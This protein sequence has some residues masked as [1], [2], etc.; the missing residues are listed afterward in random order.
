MSCKKR[1]RLHLQLPSIGSQAAFKGHSD[2]WVLPSS[3]SLQ[4][5]HWLLCPGFAPAVPIASSGWQP[6]S[7][8]IE[9]RGMLSLSTILLF[10]N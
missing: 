3:F 9:I 8:S 6:H 10:E 7:N 4:M 1:V 5:D 2:E